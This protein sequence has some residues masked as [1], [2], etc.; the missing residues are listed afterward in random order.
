MAPTRPIPNGGRRRPAAGLSSALALALGPALV[1]GPAA[2][3]ADGDVLVVRRQLEVEPLRLVEL[4]EGTL[5]GREPDGR[6][7]TVPL[8]ECLAL[9]VED[10]DARAEAPGLLVLADGQR[11]P[12]QVAADL[13][14][15]DVLAWSHARLGQLDVPVGS[16]RSVLLERGITPPVAR[17]QDIVRLTNGDLLEGLLTALGDPIRLKMVDSGAEIDIP[18]AR[19]AA[20]SIVSPDQPQRGRRVWLADGTVFDAREIRVSDDGYVRLTCS[21]SIAGT[22][23]IRLRLDDVA[24]VLFDAERLLPL[25]A[26]PPTRI[27]GPETRYALPDPE[28]LDAEAPL[29]LA[30]IRYRGPIVVRYALPPG[31]RRLAADAILPRGA[32]QWG[33]YELRILDE[34]EEVFSATM[35]ARAPAVDINVALTGTELTIEL[36]PGAH[37]AVQDELILRRAMLLVES[38]S[39]AP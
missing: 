29:G 14:P 11:F 33:D 21:W 25:A 19:V 34:D 31:T 22:Q 7:I 1:T 17:E 30:A 37:G 26:L 28:I 32:R 35:S 27:E 12:G 5:A 39:S 18:L 15:A 20:I 2:T 3:A 23:P 16:I 6:Q 24:G 10:A 36:L 8:E 38:G 13:R 9:V 4:T